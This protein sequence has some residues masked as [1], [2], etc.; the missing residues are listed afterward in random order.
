MRTTKE[1]EKA[2]I[3]LSLSAP[4]INEVLIDDLKKV[5]SVFNKVDALKLHH[6]H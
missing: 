1:V 4:N 2:D 5:V 6:C 3:V